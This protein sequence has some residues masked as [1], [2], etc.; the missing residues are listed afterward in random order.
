MQLQFQHVLEEQVVESSTPVLARETSRM[1]LVCGHGS[2]NGYGPYKEDDACNF[3]KHIQEAHHILV[4][5]SGWLESS[6]ISLLSSSEV[7]KMNDKFKEVF[8]I[9][10][11]IPS[12]YVY[13]TSFA[14]FEKHTKGIGMKLLSYMSHEGGCLNINGKV[15]T[16]PI[17]VEERPKYRGLGYG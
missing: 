4:D 8:S 6:A 3:C 2:N 12:T 14:V 11:T 13:N 10:S 16:N 1:K 17:M 7:E 9:S 5:K 15:I